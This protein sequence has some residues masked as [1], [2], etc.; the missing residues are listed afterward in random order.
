MKR[1]PLAFRVR[2]DWAIPKPPLPLPDSVIP[3]ARFHLTHA[4][5]VPSNRRIL[6]RKSP[7]RLAPKVLEKTGK[8][9]FTRIAIS[10]S[11][12][13]MLRPDVPLVANPLQLIYNAESPTI[14]PPS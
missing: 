13:S 10:M 7:S 4:E 2:N 8:N 12:F 9:L 3:V 1:Q 6:Q 11:V 5:V 14:I